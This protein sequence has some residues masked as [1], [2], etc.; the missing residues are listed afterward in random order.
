VIP[1]IGL[2]ILTH[3]AASM[4]IARDKRLVAALGA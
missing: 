1:F 2:T 4:S 3:L